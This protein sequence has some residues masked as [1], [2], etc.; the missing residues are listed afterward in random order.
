[1]RRCSPIWPATSLRVEAKA[2]EELYAT[3]ARDGSAG[4]F[5]PRLQ[6]RAGIHETIRYC[7]YAELDGSILK[8]ILP[9]PVS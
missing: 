7:E 6:R 5:L 9:A 8:S 1:M 3:I 4:V 2:P